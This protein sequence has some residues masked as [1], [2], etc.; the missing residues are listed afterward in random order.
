M[1]RLEIEGLPKK[2]NP[3]FIRVGSCEFVDRLLAAGE[4]RSTNHTNYTNVKASA[5]LWTGD[6]Y[7]RNNLRNLWTFFLRSNKVSIAL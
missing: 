4:G 2:R 3:F 1:C 5:R 6:A 7:E